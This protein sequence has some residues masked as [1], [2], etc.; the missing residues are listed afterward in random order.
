MPWLNV[1]E[2]NRTVF[3]K[4]PCAR[5]GGLLGGSS[6][7]PKMSKLQALAAA[8]KKKREEQKAETS[9]N[10]VSQVDIQHEEPSPDPSRAPPLTSSDSVP[11][12]A[13]T[14]DGTADPQDNAPVLEKAQPSTFAQAL[15]K[16]A[17][18]TPQP[19]QQL[20]AP[21]WLAFTTDE[22]LTEAFSRPSPDDVVQAAQSQ[23][24]RFARK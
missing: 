14:F 13:P 23:G 22:A 6:G 5:G 15:F 16:S 7:A 24:S 18:E 2:E 21:P 20:Y 4:P 19:Y 1:P 9:Q 10:N 8:R 3:V 11:S 12:P 17:S